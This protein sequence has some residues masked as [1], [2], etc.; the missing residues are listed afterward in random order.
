[1]KKI[2]ILDSRTYVVEVINRLT[3]IIEGRQAGRSFHLFLSGGSTPKVIYAGLAERGIDWS[4]VHLWWGDERFVPHDHA[5]SNYRMVTEQLLSRIE[6]PSL[7]VHPWPILSSPELS[8]KTYEE[9]FRRY[10]DSDDHQIDIQL[11]GMGDDGHTASLFPGTKALDEKERLC[12]ANHVEGK[13]NI[14]LSLTFPALERSQRVIF[15]VNGENKAS[16]IKEVV[17]GKRHPASKVVGRDST[18]FWLDNASAS[19]LSS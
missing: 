19:Q 7:Q 15:I 4:N 8:A 9:E 16:A 17:D 5:D 18:E 12:V 11:L 2:D 10:F 14:R 3:T 13:E 1:M 6:I